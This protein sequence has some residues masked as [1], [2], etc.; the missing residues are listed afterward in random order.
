ML[1]AMAVLCLLLGARLGFQTQS[2]RTR[3]GSTLSSG[4]DPLHPVDERP[5]AG[6][7]RVIC[8]WEGNKP[9]SKSTPVPSRRGTILSKCTPE[10]F[11]PC[12]TLWGQ[13]PPPQECMPWLHSGECHALPK[14]QTLS[15]VLQKLF[16]KKNWDTWY[17]SLLSLR[18]QEVILLC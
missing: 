12:F 10:M 1:C 11:I 18:S 5:L 6:T 13:L 2:S 14:P 7:F 9:S 3:Q 4:V 17:L 16:A 8:P 15:W